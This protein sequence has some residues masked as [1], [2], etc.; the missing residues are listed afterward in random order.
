MSVDNQF[1]A[2]VYRKVSEYFADVCDGRYSCL[3]FCA[4]ENSV[5]A[6]WAWACAGDA[7]ADVTSAGHV[8]ELFMLKTDKNR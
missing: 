7:L 4:T 3:Y 8:S 5:G 2:A 1:Y 6:G